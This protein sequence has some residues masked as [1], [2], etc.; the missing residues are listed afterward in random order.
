MIANS[1]IEKWVIGSDL[2]GF[3]KKIEKINP[4]FPRSRI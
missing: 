1:W 4:N 2:T 3:D